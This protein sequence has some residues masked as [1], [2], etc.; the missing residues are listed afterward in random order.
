MADYA[1]SQY[2][3]ASRYAKAQRV[4]RWLWQQGVTSHQLDLWTD[5]D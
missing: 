1:R 4:A 5:E 3:A 2:A